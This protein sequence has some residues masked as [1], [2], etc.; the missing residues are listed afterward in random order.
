MFL[1]VKYSFYGVNK[2]EV[3]MFGM[4]YCDF[5]M[6]WFYKSVI[7]VDKPIREDKYFIL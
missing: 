1:F 3:K 2:L 6:H 4:L 5:S 7:P